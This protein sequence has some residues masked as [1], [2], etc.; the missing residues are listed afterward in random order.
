M[1]GAPKTHVMVIPNE[2]FDAILE[3]TRNPPQMSDEVKKNWHDAIKKYREVIG[4]FK[5]TDQE[6]I[7]YV[8]A[9][10]GKDY[11]KKPL[12]IRAYQTRKESKI[13]T[14]EG[15]MTA[16]PG[17]YIIQGIKGEFYP[18]KPD[19]FEASYELVDH[20][21]GVDERD[22]F[23]EKLQKIREDHAREIQAKDEE[24]SSLQKMIYEFELMVAK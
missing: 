17:D 19:I 12:V 2:D 7:E 24:I 4:E 9:L 15:T 13:E 5:M 8:M 18:C 6:M 14:T 1:S 11:R 16:S 21:Q 10:A 23:E 3:A 20:T 22:R